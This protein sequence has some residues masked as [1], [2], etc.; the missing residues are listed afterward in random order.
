[1][2]L[3]STRCYEESDAHPDRLQGLCIAICGYGNQGHAHAL[4]LR[5]RGVAVIVGAREGGRGARAA[6]EA[7][8]ETVDFSQ[9]ARRADILMLTLPD[10]VQ[11]EVFSRD[12]QPHWKDSAVLA[13]AH[14]FALAFDQ[15][16]LPA[17]RRAFLVAPKGQGHKLRQAFLAG[18]G[19]P[20][21]LAVEGPDPEDTLGL[22][23]AYAHACGALKGGGFWSSF[24]EEAVTD[25]FGEQVVLCGGLIELV[26][27]AWETLVRRGYSRE[28]AYFECLHEVKLIVDLIAEHGIDGMRERI[29]STA[30]YGGLEA[31]SRIIDS[32]SRRQMEEVLDEIE[33][34]SFA[35]AFLTERAQGSP[36]LSA[37]IAAEAQHEIV[38][39]G[40]RL[41]ELLRRCQLGAG[42]T[43]EK[44]GN[45]G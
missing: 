32:G 33:D 28:V 11:A 43:H 38:A 18:G 29:S 4:N 22:A 31:A 14:G 37:A 44:K 30:A 23:L 2:N 12:I 42:G 19:L 5:D 21:L 24:R 35:A 9:A 36:R 45:D 13:F 39:T 17:G 41:H 1:M 40:H 10:E 6:R 15:I 16:R 7:G 3:A 26:V 34:G 27:A 8:F 20:S 25:Q